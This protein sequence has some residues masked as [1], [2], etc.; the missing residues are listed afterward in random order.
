M[1][2]FF[3]NFSVDQPGNPSTPMCDKKTKGKIAFAIG[4]VPF[5]LTVAGVISY[6]PVNKNP[7]VPYAAIALGAAT[8]LLCVTSCVG[9]YYCGWR[10][11]RRGSSSYLL[12][13]PSS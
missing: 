5:I 9:A 7:F 10:P 2:T 8:F 12:E 11:R 1:Q 4:T 3:R 6:V 13:S